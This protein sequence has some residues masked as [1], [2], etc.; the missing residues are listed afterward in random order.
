[1]HIF[2]NEYLPHYSSI[3]LINGQLPKAR[4]SILSVKKH[5]NLSALQKEKH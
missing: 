4:R 5:T 2:F 1:M 3:H